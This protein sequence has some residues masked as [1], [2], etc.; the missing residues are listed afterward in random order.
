MNYFWQIYDGAS[1]SS[2]LLAEYCGFSVPNPIFSTGPILMIHIKH[3]KPY[4]E[5]QLDITYTT[6]DKG[7]YSINN[8][9]WKLNKAVRF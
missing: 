6:S 3:D 9:P 8:A 2:H 5:E 4:H 7:L 1:T